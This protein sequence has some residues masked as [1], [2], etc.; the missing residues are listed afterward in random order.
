M[1]GRL[2]VSSTPGADP[3]EE[4]LLQYLQRKAL[5][6]LQEFQRVEAMKVSTELR[7]AGKLN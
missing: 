1:T 7:N 3:T 5:H 2:V 6:E 4:R